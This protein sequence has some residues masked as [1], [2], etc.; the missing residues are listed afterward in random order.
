LRAYS[1]NHYGSTMRTRKPQALDP[2][3]QEQ[4]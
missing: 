4:D 3:A 1:R 2:A